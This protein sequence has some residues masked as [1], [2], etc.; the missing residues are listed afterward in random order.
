MSR[1]GTWWRQLQ[2]NLLF[3]Y[4]RLVSRTASFQLEGQENREVAKT[5]GRPLIWAVWH[6]QAMAFMAYGDNFE[7]RPS[8]GAVMVGDERG[9]VL[10]TLGSR[11]EATP[12]SIDMQGN[13]VAAGRM[14]LNVIQAMKRGQQI[15]I[16]PDGP[17]GP[18]FVPKPGV[19]FLARK[20]AAAVLPVGVWT[21]QALQLRRWDR[22]LVPFPFARFHVVFGP[23]ILAEPKMNADTL[24][25]RVARELD[26]V[27]TRAQS[28]AKKKEE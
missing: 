12:Y 20:A 7:D 10:G 24:L 8:F 23:P 3:S 9:D 18:A 6:G 19:A 15:L 14:V 2:G 17:D 25:A 21:G 4:F 11:L 26:V 28:L 1:L 5:S 13:P 22:Y 27:R 16:A